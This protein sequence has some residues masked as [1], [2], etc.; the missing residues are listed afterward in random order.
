MY[1]KAT[2]IGSHITAM[3]PSVCGS[4]SDRTVDSR[5]PG[6]NV[7]LHSDFWNE[8]GFHPSVSL[9]AA[10]QSASQASSQSIKLSAMQ[11]SIRCKLSGHTLTSISSTYG[12]SA[13]Q[14]QNILQSRMQ[15]LLDEATSLWCS[16]LWDT[17][18]LHAVRH[19][20][21]YEYRGCVRLLGETISEEI[22]APPCPVVEAVRRRTKYVSDTEHVRYRLRMVCLVQV[23]IPS[24]T[25]LLCLPAWP[26]LSLCRGDLGATLC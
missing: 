26:R 18:T 22:G 17:R 7:T 5:F 1:R 13:V 9:S 19:C 6:R 14:Q 23:P 8:S 3:A 24:V 11:Q 16:F 4:W 10:L 12:Y 2:L 25:S 20:L 15:S 21:S